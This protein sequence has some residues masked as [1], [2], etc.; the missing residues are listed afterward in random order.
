MQPVRKALAI[1]RAVDSMY[2]RLEE[3]G[4]IAAFD[5]ESPETTQA[6]K[7]I[8]D[9]AFNEQYGSAFQN[10]VFNKL[11]MAHPE[12]LAKMQQISRLSEPIM[13]LGLARKAIEAASAI[14]N[15]GLAKRLS[16]IPASTKHQPWYST[17][18]TTNLSREK[19][20]MPIEEAEQLFLQRTLLFED[21]SK[22]FPYPT[23]RLLANAEATMVG[24]LPEHTDQR[25]YQ[26]GHL[27]VEA[28]AFPFT[29]INLAMQGCERN[30]YCTN[31]NIECHLTA[32]DL[33][34]ELERIGVI[35][36][37][38]IKLLQCD[39]ENTPKIADENGKT[40]QFHYATITQLV[41]PR[42]RVQSIA[43]NLVENFGINTVV[44][45]GAH[46]MAT[47]LYEPLDNIELPGDVRPRI[48]A[49]PEARLVT[50][51]DVKMNELVAQ[52]NYGCY[53]TS[54]VYSV[55]STDPNISYGH[56]FNSGLFTKYYIERQLKPD[57]QR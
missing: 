57:L 1:V 40:V 43:K 50:I 11:H 4:A 33:I 42:S 39:M 41:Q 5:P 46:Q 26:E 36:V 10:S 29:A 35:P 7:E 31:S 23:Y 54:H 55:H 47:L 28:G 8:W 17:C 53:N 49:V 44:M 32:Q 25:F 52:H 14:E 16:E 30:I 12:T 27:I 13:E 19:P 3:L 15:N 48:V 37:G 24:A 18:G 21:I 45:R 2:Q 38:T 22:D 51:E 34:H 20:I 56:L 6:F 9:A